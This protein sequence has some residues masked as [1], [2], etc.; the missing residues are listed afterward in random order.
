MTNLSLNATASEWIVQTGLLNCSEITFL[1]NC[2]DDAFI[3]GEPVGPHGSGLDAELF[4]MGPPPGS[5][6][7][8]GPFPMG[9]PPDSGLDPGPF[10]I[11]PPP[12][13]P[14]AY[15]DP[16]LFF[17]LEMII[18]SGLINMV[19]V[20]GS[21]GN[22]MSIIILCKHGLRSSSMNIALVSMAVADLLILITLPLRKVNL[23]VGLCDKVLARTVE[24][25]VLA[26]GFLAL[27]R[28]WAIIS[29]S[30][31]VVIAVERFLAVY[32][33]FKVRLWVTPLKMALICVSTHVVWYVLLWPMH[34]TFSLLW[35]T[36]PSTNRSVAVAWVSDFHLRHE[37]TINFYISY[38]INLI[39][40]SLQLI[41]VVVCSVAVSIRVISMGQKRKQISSVGAV[42]ATATAIARRRRT[43]WTAR[44]VTG[45]CK[46]SEQTTSSATDHTLLDRANDQ[47]SVIA[48]EMQDGAERKSAE[49][50]PKK[51]V[52]DEISSSHTPN[53]IM[54]PG[55][56][57]S[58]NQK[59]PPP[60]NE[61]RHKPSSSIDLKVVKMLLLVCLAYIIFILPT[62]L[63]FVFQQVYPELKQPRYV[64]VNF[65]MTS[66][67]MLLLALN[68]AINF[69]IYVYNSVK[70]RKSFHQL[71]RCQ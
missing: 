34:T 56:L 64:R 9:P 27:N 4:P 54:V 59:V 7:D 12:I 10:P 51:Q 18:N 17:V 33:P 25:H 53:T 5:G 1:G 41:I 50:E 31:V 43:S 29:H 47:D 71:C 62:F 3:L 48:K 15:I 30:H 49:E 68:S 38:G 46:T 36:V 61:W 60:E 45:S 37:K 39:N 42:T 67:S 8:P 24:S 26:H 55:K 44:S 19:A 58:T 22:I 66:I 65:L 28:T 16:K 32:F 35:A 13:P 63:L 57:N 2:T 40:V 23:L 69:I 20:L 70:F 11:G 14:D 52:E 6:L 21:A